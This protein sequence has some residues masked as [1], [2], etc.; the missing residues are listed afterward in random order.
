MARD[1]EA[2][3][4]GHAR[5]KWPCPMCGTAKWLKPPKANDAVITLV[6]GGEMFA[7]AWICV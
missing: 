7:A 3:H 4:T 1:E 2:E 6:D 5:D